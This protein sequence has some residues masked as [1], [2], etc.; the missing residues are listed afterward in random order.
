M[1]WVQ[2]KP[3][4]DERKYDKDHMLKRKP[5]KYLYVNQGC[6]Y[7]TNTNR[8]NRYLQISTFTVTVRIIIGTTQT[9]PH[10]PRTCKT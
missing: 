3:R 6:G 9:L 8:Y 2:K 4:T 1:W 5:G 7:F 10:K